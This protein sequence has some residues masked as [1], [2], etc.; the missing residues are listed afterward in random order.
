[1]ADDDRILGSSEFVVKPLSEIEEKEKQF[2]HLSRRIPDLSFFA[3]QVAMS[4]G[5]DG[6]ALQAGNRKRAI[7]KARKLFCQISVRSLGYSAICS[8]YVSVLCVASNGM[9]PQ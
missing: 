7:V 6:D 9:V 5:I 3:G 2:L 4:E 1:M 8:S